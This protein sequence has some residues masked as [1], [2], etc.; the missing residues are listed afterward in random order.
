VHAIAKPKAVV[1]VEEERLG[2]GEFELN[3]RCDALTIGRSGEKGRGVGAAARSSTIRLLTYGSL[4]K[5]R[6]GARKKW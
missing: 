4:E 6:R 2:A 3:G 5:F 1:L